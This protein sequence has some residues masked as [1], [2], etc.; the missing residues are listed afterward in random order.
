MAKGMSR[1][2]GPAPTSTDRSHKAKANAE[3]WVSLPPEG[4]DGPLPAF[5]LAFPAERELELWERLWESP[6]AVM[7]EQ[8]HQEFEVASYV[9][10]LFRAESPRGSFNYWSQVKQIGE[11]LGLSVSGMARNRWTITKVEAEDDETT[12]QVNA[13]VTSLADRLKVARGG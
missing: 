6:Q 4:R 1:N 5:P 7:W 3:G 2:S 10:C 11:S 12:P 9:R 13:Q 8:L